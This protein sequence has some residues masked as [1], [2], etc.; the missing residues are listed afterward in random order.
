MRPT[1]DRILFEQA[2]SCMAVFDTAMRYLMATRRYVTDFR[3]GVDGPAALVGRSHDDVFPGLPEYW[4]EVHRRVLAG[5]TLSNPDDSFRREDGHIEWLSWEMSPWRHEDGTIGGAF[6]VTEVVT[7]RKQAELALRE[8]EARLLRAQKAGAVGSWEWWIGTDR[9]FWSDGLRLL[10]GLPLDTPPSHAAFMARVH[11][12]D[13]QRVIRVLADLPTDSE[14]PV[15]TVYRINRADTGEERWLAGRANVELGPDGQPHRVLGVTM[16][17]TGKRRAE[18]QLRAAEARFRALF[19]ACPIALMLIDPQTRRFVA[20][21]D[22]AC[23]ALGYTREEFAALPAPNHTVGV[24]HEALFVA[25]ATPG[26]RPGF[27]IRL[28]AKSGEI[29][30]MLVS[31]SRVTIDGQDLICAARIDITEARARERERRRLAEQQSA[32][33]DATATNIALL[34]AAGTI[35]AVNA[36][37]RDFAAEGGLARCDPRTDIGANY[38][39]ACASAAAAGDPTAIAVIDGLHDVLA[40][41]RERLEQVYPCN[42]ADGTER[43]FRLVATPVLSGGANSGAVVT[44]IDITSVLLDQ[45]AIAEREA[46]LISILETVPD[47]MVVIDE[48][49]MIESFSAAAERMFGWQAAEAVGQHIV[50]LM[51]AAEPGAH[52]DYLARYRATGKRREIGENRVVTGQ[53]RDG[54]HFPMELTVG[55]MRVAGRRL[56]TGF[57]RD[58]THQHETQARLRELQAEL[59]HVSRLREAGMLASALSHELN[60]P[61]TSVATALRAAMRMLADPA[62]SPEA[63]DGVRE[64]VELAAEQSLRAGGMIRTLREFVSRGT[65]Q[66]RPENVVRLIEDAATLALAGLQ[67]MPI[68]VSFALSPALPPVLADRVQIQ[69]VL[70]N[71]LRN[72]VQAMTDT[73]RPA[74]TDT[75]RPA[76]TD[77]PRPAMTDT[78][79]SAVPPTLLV[80]AWPDAASGTVEIAIADTG[81][82]LA[83][84]I[85]AR[86]FEPFVTTKPGGMGVGLSI[87][88]AITE[89]HEGRI[90]A[91]PNPGGGTIFRLSLP[92]MTS[93]EAALARPSSAEATPENVP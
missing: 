27:T 77:T 5:E 67:H 45:R 85:A 47:A 2:P 72:A 84:D 64:A 38:L 24:S 78:P 86:L 58:L 83:P 35:V 62:P 7:A 75:P 40:G 90:W 30:D 16:D 69:Q 88:R 92:T 26:P 14:T 71:L 19:D 13:R 48:A 80:R 76:M 3:L 68:R 59:L 93:D 91:E 33:L 57:A 25:Q 12:D 34:D 6:L 10:F 11:P 56:F 4:L 20:Y 53:R 43:W 89:A 51:P 8:N 22:L 15:E 65:I 42:H 29:R 18:E 36:A 52:D 66:R 63:L 60:Q 46:R 31:S 21:N 79:P 28:R 44:H 54:Q 41:Q 61:L 32:I 81:P 23:V 49:G 17:V 55:E 39:A 1:P 70:F 87:C 82:G 50:I 9:D 37:W 73:P 74:M